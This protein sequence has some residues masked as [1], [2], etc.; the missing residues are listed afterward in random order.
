METPLDDQPITLSNGQGKT[1]SP[2]N[3]DHKFSGQVPLLTAL[4][5]SMNVPTV[6][7]GLAVGV[8]AVASTLDAAGWREPIPEYPSMFLGALNGSPLMVAQVYQTLADNG[9]YR[10]LTAVTTVLDSHNKPLPE[11]ARPAEQAINPATDY[12]VKYAMTQVVKSGT[13]KRLGRAFPH[14]TLAGKTGTSNDSRDSWFAGFDERNVAAVWVGRDDNG[15]TNL[16]GSSGAMAVYQA[17][18]NQR[19]PLSLRL[20]PVNGVVQ[21]YFEK[22]TGVAKERTCPNV[23]Q[24]PAIAAGYNPAPNCGDPLPWWKRMLG[25]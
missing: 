11:V 8:G 9:R 4:K 20:T 25:N 2:K 22:A 12:L 7:L 14:T 19:P 23:V 6:N 18:L 3:F 21:G 17:F 13:A 5:N 1:W 10:K 15:K 16:Y 24:L